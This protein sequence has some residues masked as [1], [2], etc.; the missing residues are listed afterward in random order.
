MEEEKNILDY[1]YAYRD[2][3][4]RELPFNEVDNVVLSELSYIPFEKILHGRFKTMTVHDLCARYFSSVRYA[5]FMKEAKWFQK[6]IFLALALF[7]SKRYGPIR[8]EQFKNVF[9]KDVEAQFTGMLLVLPDHTMSIVF[10]GTDSS[11]LGWKEDFNMI[12][13]DETTGQKM[14]REFM[15]RCLVRHPRM[16]FRVMGHSK[17]GVLAVYSCLELTASQR[18][19]L[20]QIYNNDG[21]GLHKSKYES[22]GYRAIKDKITHIVPV[23]SIV[24]VLLFHDQI[25]A[26]VPY[27]TGTDLMTAHDAYTWLVDGTQ[28]RRGTRSPL[29]YYFDAALLDAVSNLPL[30]ERKK[31]VDVFFKALEEVGYHTANE[32]FSDFPAATKKIGLFLFREMR[33]EKAIGAV[34]K[35]MISSFR[36]CYVVYAARAKAQKKALKEENA[37]K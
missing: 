24:G 30:E 25:T 26:A 1:L 4:F 10:R 18:K 37:E 11:I 28:F 9:N 6:Y 23:D 36:K 15:K 8:V 20:V 12:Y 19:R 31:F 13:M 34:V 33:K 2:K 32:I 17:G 3:S 29:S 35:Q 7:D 5:D 16:P 21:P 22:E 27:E 14:S